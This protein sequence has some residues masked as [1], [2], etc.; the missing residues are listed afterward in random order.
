VQQ[1]ATPQSGQPQRVSPTQLRLAEP[2]RIKM[3]RRNMND[4]MPNGT[5]ILRLHVDEL[6]A[7]RRTSIASSSGNAVLDSAAAQAMSGARFVPYR[8]AGVAVAVT[9]LMP[10]NIKGSLQCRGLGPL[11]C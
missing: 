8:E 10:M 4:P 3:P 5:A 11:D 7:V 6:G 9:T 1:A 2:L